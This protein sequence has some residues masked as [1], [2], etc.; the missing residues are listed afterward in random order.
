MTP[1][2]PG[3]AGKD[4]RLENHANSENPASDHSASE[5][6]STTAASA[7]KSSSLNPTQECPFHIVGIGASAGGLEALEA[8]FDNVPR[9]SGM[10][11][12]VVQHLSPDFKSVMDELLAR[13]TKIRIFRVTDGMTV[14]PNAIYLIPPKKEMVIDG[15]KLRLS[16]KEPNSGLALPIDI[17]F[18]SLA[19]DARHCAI[20]VIL[21]G[22]G[23]DGSKGLV[24]IKQ[25]GGLAIAQEPES[26]RFDGMP[27]S[28]IETGAVDQILPPEEIP[29]AIM[30]HSRNALMD[31]PT[32]NLLESPKLL[33]GFDAI[34]QLLRRQHDIDFSHYKRPTVTRRVQRRLQMNQIVDIEEYVERLRTD[35][36]EV[37]LL[38]RD[39]LIGVTKFFR[40]GDAFRKIERDVFPE[41]LAKA[42]SEGEL[43]IWVAGCATG[44]EAYSLAI[45]LHEQM[46]SME[47][48]PNVKI[49]ATDVHRASLNTASAGVYSEES[50]SEVTPARLARYF[51]RVKSGY[52][53]SQ[54]LRQMIVFAPHNLIKDAP[55]TKIDL[56]TCR[57]LLIYFE[58]VAQRKVISLFHFALNTGGIMVLGPSESPGDLAEEF[59]SLDDRWKIYRKR[60]DKRLPTDLR[61]PI[62][63]NYLSTRRPGLSATPAAAPDAALLR[64]Y[65][66]L[67][68]DFAPS[69]LL[70]NE[71]RELV[72]SFGGASAYLQL[73]DGRPST[74]ILELVQ[75]ELRIPIS[76]AMHQAAKLRAPVTLEGV[77][78]SKEA[79]EQVI[80]LGVRPYFDP[81]SA[82]AHYLVS[83]QTEQ[84]RQRVTPSQES[85]SLAQA[86]K[87]QFQAMEVELRY[88]KENLQ[89]TLEEMETSNEEL[90]ATNEELVASNEELQ[91]TNEEL[92]SVNE[93]LYT[94]NAEY[95]KKI[96]E[97]TEV[98]ADLENLLRSTEIGVIFL[99]R[100][101]CIRKFTPKMAE[102]F[103][104][105]PYDVGRRID[106]FAHN[107]RRDHLLDDLR[108]VLREEMV[109]EADVPGP[110]GQTFLLRILPYRS[111]E[112][113]EGVVLT[114]I[115]VTQLKRV[116]ADLRFM[117]KVYVDGADP[118][119]VEDLD[120]R[121]TDVNA[122]ALRV[123]GWTRP[124]L[125]GR[126]VDALIPPK[127]RLRAKQLRAQCL[128]NG[129]LRNVETHKQNR[130]TDLIPVLLTLSVLLD[131]GG[132]PVALASNVKDITARVRAEEAARDAVRKRDQFLAMLSHELRNPLGA[133]LNA[134]YL[135][136]LG[137]KGQVPPMVREACE[138]IQ[139]QML[140][141]AR[142]LDDL[143]D[144]SRIT[145]GKIQIRHERVDL[146]LLI[147][148]AV[149]AVQPQLDSYGHQLTIDCANSPMVVEGDATRLLQIM[150]NLLANAAKYTPA[151]GEIHLS[152]K[153]EQEEAVLRVRDDGRGIPTHML[154]SIFEMFV[155]SEHSL[156]R[157]HGGMGIGLT[158][159]R[160][161][162]GLHHGSIRAFSDGPG[163]G[164]EFVVRLPLASSSAMIHTNNSQPVK[165][166]QKHIVIVEDNEDSRKMME[167]LLKME[168]HQVSSAKDGKQGLEM[169]LRLRPDAAIVD[170]G[171]PEMTGYEVAASVRK[172]LP[173]EPICLVALTGYG[174]SEDRA[175]ALEAGFTAHVVKPV[176][177]HELDK[178]LS[179]TGSKKVS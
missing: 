110:D 174:R 162:V 124:E 27:K 37:N 49:F 43:R 111:K 133:A 48:Q 11:F 109:I 13:H 21:S 155:Q 90:Q 130:A 19:R 55:F 98:T 68:S 78:L 165:P 149:Q 102:L 156:D 166:A 39:L 151:R 128:E 4:S 172:E 33:S 116:E 126:S 161:L 178:L 157:T 114:L 177:P 25:A 153:K 41:L 62:S 2:M 106:S 125:L 75:P 123:F 134:T 8:F 35:P 159:V 86:S 40:D 71:Q 95:Q 46:E 104:L 17:F 47:K 12:V 9:D 139:R 145:Q 143:L 112:K 45:L 170:I 179:E 36:Q 38:Y 74:D 66:G 138:V 131:E 88:T 6:A 147:K 63:A 163:R 54:D 24:E 3:E 60:R 96:D 30:A 61:L 7:E 72:Q 42:Q 132:K 79:Q 99:D 10:A 51:T 93:E 92:H 31:E 140:Q 52:L 137:L 29:S 77:R 14:E 97:L 83:F 141:V 22:T 148:D 64:V 89:A 91:S 81:K 82:S 56:I 135:F 85:I 101:L 94:V 169:I 16:D 34:F 150:E 136:D 142:L 107:I 168:G 160:T 26:A 173:N 167:A 127:E 18:R 120:G 154:E 76:T 146:T 73:R 28:A 67:L 171:L 176:K 53:V 100:D 119:V 5:G 108:R 105:L 118:I 152:L 69:S 58:P 103:H 144:V 70:I 15:G 80:T 117:S 84:A 1:M 87:D 23:S 129:G 50:L 20:G 65:D 113:I 158:L 32:R 115:D 175:A 121:I 164:S 59:A 57:N 122:E 44:E